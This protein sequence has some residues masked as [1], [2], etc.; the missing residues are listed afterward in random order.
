MKK[1]LLF[2]FAVITYNL[3]FG[4]TNPVQNL[5]WSHTHIYP[6]NNIYYLNWNQPET[7]HNDLI[8]YNIYRGNELFR[9]QTNTSLGCDSRFGITEGCDFLFYNGGVPFTGY[10]AAVYAGGVESEYVSFNVYGP[11][12]DVTDILLKP[13][14]IFP[15]PAKNTLNFSEELSNIRIADLTGKI[16]KQSYV[17]EKSV[18]ISKLAKGI[19]LISAVTKSGEAVSKKFI[20]E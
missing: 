14:N 4:Q 17:S 19:Y 13:I 5:E 11:A 15:N 2:I 12:L 3:A 18:D 8:G 16:V 20:K 10:V 7:P 9:F 6:Y 1:F